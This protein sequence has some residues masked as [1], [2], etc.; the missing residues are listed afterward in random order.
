[1]MISSKNTRAF[2]LISRLALVL[3]IAGCT[4]SLDT[5]GS[6]G[7]E[8]SAVTGMV[9]GPE[10][11]PLSNAIVRFRP[12]EY[13]AD[14]AQSA[15]Y[16][17]SHTL[18]D[19]ITGADGS[20]SISK[21]VP[22]DYSVEI[23]YD[24]SLSVCYPFRYE[25][26]NQELQL[27]ALRA[28]PLAQLSG[29]V[30]ISYGPDAYCIV[31]VYG[32]DRA[33]RPDAFGN[34]SIMV[35]EGNHTIHIGG[36]TKDSLNKVEFDGM[37]LSCN[38]GWGEDKNIGY[39]YLKPP[40]P[41][42]CLDGMCDTFVVRRVLDMAGMQMVR[43]YEVT[44]AENGRIVEL[45]LRGRPLPYGVSSEINRLIELRVLDL[46]MTGLP[47][48]FPDMGR[49][50]KLEIIRLDGNHIP[51]FSSGIGNCTALK[52]LNLNGNELTALPPSIISLTTLTYLN[53][54][55]NHLC[56]VDPAMAEWIDRFD[57]V[58]RTSQRCQ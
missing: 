27:P 13:L 20:F 42:P 38:V 35:P 2:L 34:F 47:A 43:V 16:I 52:E 28:L 40:P 12:S 44:K 9:V 39:Y 22:D 58:W 18:F 11:N 57:P 37:D 6:S 1:M 10:G 33:A 31:Q 21:M 23:A 48:I 24:D 4:S 17:S 15:S 26:E 51:M 54:G 56:W 32:L 55:N 36:Y 7:T 25:T 19:T 53:V 45:N 29:S 5:G 14:S 30:Q 8:V 49:M 46:G 41:P 3:M 50:T